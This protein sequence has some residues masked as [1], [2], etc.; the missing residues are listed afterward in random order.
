LRANAARRR[1]RF[2]AGGSEIPLPDS[3]GPA[4]TFEGGRESR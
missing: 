4:P 1:A 3:L 2:D